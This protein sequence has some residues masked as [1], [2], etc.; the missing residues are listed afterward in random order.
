MMSIEIFEAKSKMYITTFLFH[1]EA[2]IEDIRNGL[3]AADRL[4][5]YDELFFEIAGLR[6]FVYPRTYS[7]AL[8]VQITENI[9]NRVKKTK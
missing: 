2:S 1:K 9:R 8:A 4:A 7:A 5:Y 6:Y 3:M